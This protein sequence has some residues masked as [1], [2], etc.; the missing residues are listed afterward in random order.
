MNRGCGLP[1]RSPFGGNV[2]ISSALQVFGV[3]KDAIQP[4]LAQIKLGTGALLTDALITEVVKQAAATVC[5]AYVSAGVD[6]AELAASTSS[7]GYNQARHLITIRAVVLLAFSIG[8]VG[9][10]ME[11]ALQDL[12]DEYRSAIAEL[13]ATPSAMADDSTD[14]P[15]TVPSTAQIEA[16]S[17]TTTRRWAKP[18]M[19]W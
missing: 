2:S 13:R 10:G 15:S 16:G 5:A 7:I 17:W 3:D 1:G 19:G 11:D 14:L 4:F 9:V 8:G 12:R 18:S 6:V